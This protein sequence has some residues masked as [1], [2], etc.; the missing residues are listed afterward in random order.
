MTT[1]P[2]TTPTIRVNYVAG[3]KRAKRWG[4]FW[5]EYPYGPGTRPKPRAVFFE[6]EVEAQTFRTRT[7]DALAAEPPTA[8]TPP[9]DLR[10]V[11]GFLAVWLLDHIKPLR[12]VATWR[13]YHGLVRFHI[14]PKLG[15]LKM[16][17]LTPL[18]VLAFY[19]ELY[20]DGVSL[21][22]RRHVHTCLSSACNYAIIHEALATNPCAQQGRFLRHKD[23]QEQE[24]EPNP[25]SVSEA[26]QF[27][28]WLEKH[29]P[30][31]YDYFLF[32]HDT[33]ARVGEV[34][35]LKWANVSLENAKATI[36]ESYSPSVKA[37]INAAEKAA[38]RRG[39]G[40]GERDGEKAT[41]THQSRTIDLTT[42][43]VERLLKWRQEQRVQ[44]LRR[45]RKV[46]IYVLTNRRGSPRRQDGNMRR[47]FDRGMQ[48]CGIAGH[49]PHDL[50]D[51]FASTH[52]SQD[53]GKLGWVSRQL[54]HKSPTTTE[55][56]YFKF[57]STTASAGYADQI[58]AV[59]KP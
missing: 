53:W 6:T 35:A 29:A 30:A 26:A 57:K 24:P 13:S 15:H 51:T 34:A 8:N 31:W 45:G 14:T 42:E 4:A 43:V 27:F 46:P 54:G 23:E 38:G 41:K 7:L 25:L 48:G 20:A 52:L 32:L 5:N 59:S 3:G 9:P 28:A 10:R 16:R 33:G 56:H 58:R 50:R 47:V 21:A 22:T 19:N 18:K 11:D 2:S 49:H 39:T 40:T 12:E 17:E 1:R 44:S 37:H 36:S 55:R